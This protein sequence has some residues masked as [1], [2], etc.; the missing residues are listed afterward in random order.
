MVSILQVNPLNKPN[1]NVGTDEPASQIIIVKTQAGQMVKGL[2]SS[3]FEIGT[4]VELPKPYAAFPL[5]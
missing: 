2:S 1:P 4:V 5:A 3:N